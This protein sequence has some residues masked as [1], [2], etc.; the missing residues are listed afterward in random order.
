[1]SMYL[2]KYVVLCYEREALFHCASRVA[3]SA[4]CN[5]SVS[6]ETRMPLIQEEDASQSQ[7]LSTCRMGMK[8]QE[9]T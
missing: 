5:L 7:V 8:D 2:A 3:C 1:M 4:R 6:S 9:K